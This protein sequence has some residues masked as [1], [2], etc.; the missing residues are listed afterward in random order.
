M[1]TN[2]LSSYAIFTYQCGGLTWSGSTVFAVVGYNAFGAFLANHPLSGTVDIAER[3]PCSCAQLPWFN[4][5]YALPS[6]AVTTNQVNRVLCYGRYF[7][8]IQ[9]DPQIGPRIQGFQL[10]IIQFFLPA[11]PCSGFQARFDFRYR[12]YFF[13][14]S[15]G[16]VTT[17]YV[18]RFLRFTPFYGFGPTRMCCYR[19]F[20]FF[21]FFFRG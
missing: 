7:T 10:F 15:F 12:L 19:T 4:I 16:E 3:L 9:Q 8:D 1:I 11:C 13:S 18:P 21:F 5:I 20:F 6:T 2:G 17:C 14:F